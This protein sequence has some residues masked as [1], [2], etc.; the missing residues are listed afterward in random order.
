MF[1]NSSAVEHSAVNRT[2]AGSNPAWGVFLWLVGQVVKTRPFHGCNRGSNPLRVIFWRHSQVV[3]QRSAKPLCISSN[4]IGAFI[5]G[6]A[7]FVVY[8]SWTL[9]LSV[10]L[11][12]SFCAGFR[13]LIA[14]L[15]VLVFKMWILFC[16]FCCLLF[17][18]LKEIFLSKIFDCI[19]IYLFYL[20]FCLGKNC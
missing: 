9:A 1:L 11:S 19:F 3:R 12:G 7:F 15:M 16:V 17:V 6:T 10:S 8:F 5:F 20:P 18:T 13:S 4:L 2:V 14:F